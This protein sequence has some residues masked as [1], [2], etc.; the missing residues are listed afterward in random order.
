[1]SE[2]LNLAEKFKQQSDK[3]AKTIEMEIET[4]MKLLEDYM[5]VK[6]SESENII[7]KGMENL[8][9]TNEQ[10]QEMLTTEKAAIDTALT[11]YLQQLQDPL[12]QDLDTLVKQTQEKI[13]SYSE[14]I[15]TLIQKREDRL[16]RVIKTEMKTWGIVAGIVAIIIFMLGTLLGAVMISKFSKPIFIQLPSQQ[17]SI[18][19]AQLNRTQR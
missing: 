4:V 14:R 7:K 6:L 2:I 1:M 3:Q 18:D 15:E 16:A 10:I 12:S 19:Y 9:M 11:T 8:S 17:Q 5:K 13:E